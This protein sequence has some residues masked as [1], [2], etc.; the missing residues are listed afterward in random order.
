MLN[1]LSSIEQEENNRQGN[2]AD[3]PI[4]AQFTY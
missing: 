2:Q 4:V 1:S 3:E